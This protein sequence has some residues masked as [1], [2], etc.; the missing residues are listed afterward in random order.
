VSNELISWASRNQGG[1]PPKTDL[2][3]KLMEVDELLVRKQFPPISKFWKDA[4]ERFYA[5]GRRRLV[6]RVGRRGGKS[7][8]LAR[9]AVIE[10]LYGD[11][12]V[13]P[14]DV[15]VFAFVSVTR[16][17]ARQRLSTIAEILDVLK[18]SYTR[19]GDEI[20]LNNTNRLF[21]VYSASFRTAVGFTCIGMVADEAAKWRDDDTGANP[22][23]EVLRSMRP[24]MATMPNAH[25]FLSSSPWATLDAHHEHMELGDTE[26]QNVESAPTWVANP[27][28]TEAQCR[29]LEADEETF[30]REYGAIPMR[31]GVSIFFDS[32]AIEDSVLKDWT[33][34]RTPR[35]GEQVTCG[36]DFGFKSDFSALYISHL[37]GGMYMPGELVVLKPQKDRPL[38]PSEVAKAFAETISKHGSQGVMADGHYREA[39]V[40]HLAPFRLALLDAPAQPVKAFI[41]ART[42]LH[43]DRIRLPNDKTLLRDLREIQKRP[44]PNSHIRIILPR[45]SGGGHSD[46]VSAFVNSV[47]QRAGAVVIDRDKLKAARARRDPEAEMYAKYLRAQRN[48]DAEYSTYTEREWITTNS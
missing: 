17:E 38:K 31:G 7:S 47:W 11:H 16:R 32:R 1:G 24:A 44:T 34:P 21:R 26:H 40:E 15:G 25:E 23:T 48:P 28:L 19:R 27:T 6:L 8:T 37:L 3:Q 18:V 46:M 12:Q 43:Q 13:P 5:T 29:E 9:V 4:L 41:R 45:R 10:T 22:A 33:N 30:Q 14:G 36:A 42:L 20:E 35:I 2:F 39:M